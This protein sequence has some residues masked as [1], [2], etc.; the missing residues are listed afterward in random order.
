[1]KSRSST[2]FFILITGIFVIMFAFSAAALQ[3][4]SPI[5]TERECSLKLTYHSKEKYFEGMEIQIFHVADVSSDSKYTLTDTF[6]AYPININAITS[7]TEWDSAASTLTAY[8][9]AD[10]VSPT[11]KSVTDKNGIVRFTDLKTGLYLVRWT[12][13]Q[14]KDT[15]YGFEPFMIALPSLDDNAEWTYDVDCYPKPGEPDTP[16]NEEIEYKVVVLWDDLGFE[17]QRPDSVQVEV[18]KDGVSVGIYTVTE[19]ENWTFTWTAIDDGS[20]WTVVEYVTG[21]KYDVT[22]TRFGNVFTIVNYYRGTAESRKPDNKN[23]YY[24][25]S[26]NTNSRNTG[27]YNSSQTIR[28]DSNINPLKT[29]THSN[30]L[31]YL[32]VV[33]IISGIISVTLAVNGRRLNDDQ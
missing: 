32:M 15:I 28:Y 16:T 31:V 4:Y 5:D 12:K 33:S 19:L 11:Q 29:G 24:T 18:F 2:R 26:N 23:S 10:S 21:L 8:I 27:Y 22:V 6:K 20:V 9:I 17:D 1:M 3:T 30:S 25:N 14:T 7:Q 13:N